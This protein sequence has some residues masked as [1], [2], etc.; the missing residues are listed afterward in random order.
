M[1]GQLRGLLV[2]N[3]KADITPLHGTCALSPVEWD[4]GWQAQT[5]L[6]P[7]CLLSHRATSLI[8][9]RSQCCDHDPWRFSFHLPHPALDRQVFHLLPHSLLGF[10]TLLN[11]YFYAKMLFSCRLNALPFH[12]IVSKYASCL[13]ANVCTLTLFCLV[14]FFCNNHLP[15]IEHS[16]SDRQRKEPVDMRRTRN[17]Y[18]R[19]ALPAEGRPRA[20]FGYA[21]CWE[22]FKCV[23]SPLPFSLGFLFMKFNSVHSQKKHV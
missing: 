17:K 20:C 18:C 16:M 1:W 6:Q 9:G 3:Q 5:W 15:W 7:C 11:A 21:G 23:V 12:T 8:R 10:Q 13:K 19:Y 4:G 2:S 14:N 22:A